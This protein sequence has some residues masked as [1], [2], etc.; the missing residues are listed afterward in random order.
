VAKAEKR[1]G[2]LGIL[3]TSNNHI[4]GVAATDRSEFIIPVK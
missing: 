2:K 1:E 4:P 3:V